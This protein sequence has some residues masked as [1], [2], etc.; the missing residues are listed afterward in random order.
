[1]LGL[2]LDYSLDK[3]LTAYTYYTSMDNS[4]K[5]VKPVVYVPGDNEWTDCHRTN[6]GSYN[7]LEHL[8]HLRRVMCPSMDSLGQ[9]H[10]GQRPWLGHCGASRCGF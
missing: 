5:M 1:M 7:T 2:E 4:G 10:P 3:T 9:S 8:P 6:T